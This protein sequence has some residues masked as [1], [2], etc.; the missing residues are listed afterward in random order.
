MSHSYSLHCASSLFT[1]R[2]PFRPFHY[3]FLQY[4]P[5]SLLTLVTLPSS[6]SLSKP[7]LLFP[8]LPS[9]LIIYPTLPHLHSPHLIPLPN[10]IYFTSSH[11]DRHHFFHSFPNFF[12][13]CFPL[14]SPSQLT[15]PSSTSFPELSLPL[16]YTFLFMSI[17]PTSSH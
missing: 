7:L 6:T 15:L 3:F 10:S 8:Y 5:L 2:Q 17:H 11:F 4:F 16:H 9:F 1:L 13:Y 14:S 12:L